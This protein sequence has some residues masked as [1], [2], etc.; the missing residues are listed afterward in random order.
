M[1][2][3]EKANPKKP[4]CSQTTEFTGAQLRT[5]LYCPRHDSPT[6]KHDRYTTGASKP[7]THLASKAP[8]PYNPNIQCRKGSILHP[9]TLLV[10]VCLPP[11]IFIT[12]GG[13]LFGPGS[14][15]S[16]ISPSAIAYAREFRRY[17]RIWRDDPRGMVPTGIHQGGGVGGVHKWENETFLTI[18]D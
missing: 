2:G 11:V 7:L 10:A 6:I 14:P 13:A 15:A 5:P 9:C 12:L 3:K 17:G 18:V 1:Q 16:P 8:R 4:F